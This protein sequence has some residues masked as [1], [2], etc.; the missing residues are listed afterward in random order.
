MNAAD[1]IAALGNRLGVVDAKAVRPGVYQLAIPAWMADR[2]AAAIYVRPLPDG[3]LRVSDL[4]QTCMRLSYTQKLEDAEL[5]ALD[6]VAGNH[7]ISLADGELAVDVP[8]SELLA[9]TLGLVQVESAAEASIRANA[10]R[11]ATSES[12]TTAVRAILVEKFNGACRLDY[13]DEADDP[14]QHWP[15][16][17]L[18][19]IRGTSV[20]IA[21]IPSALE[22]ERAIG[23]KLHFEPK[24]KA[25]SGR[26]RWVALPR[27]LGEL[28]ERLQGKVMSEYW[29]PTRV[30]DEDRAKAV[31]KIEEFAV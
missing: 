18:I 13:V 30:F 2:D 26:H 12:F 19:D 11:R 29:V 27:N 23:T 7:G 8:P 28:T 4:G 31:A 5:E 24:M 20:G 21:I 1:I 25:A 15:I 22:A 9:A 3:R 6:R 16:D 17:A 10:M 14:N